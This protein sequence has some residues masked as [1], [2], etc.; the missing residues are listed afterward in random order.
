MTRIKIK[1][2]AALVSFSLTLSAGRSQTSTPPAQTSAPPTTLSQLQEHL[3]DHIGDPKFA[4]AIW[5]VKIVSLD[6]GKTLF[7]SNPQKLL[8]PAS[9]SKLYTIALALDR[10]GANG[11]IKT[12]LYAKARPRNDGVLAGDLIVYGRGDPTLNARLNSNDI[13]RALQPLVAVL[14]NAGV[15][16]IE[17]DLIGDSR[18]LQ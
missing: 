12:S 17:G 13:Y 2:C 5:G 8:S 15:Q 7:E 3:A 1:W 16:R 9:N 10:L 6:S 18:F 4:A 14:T 11:R